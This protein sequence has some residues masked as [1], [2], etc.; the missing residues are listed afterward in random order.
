MTIKVWNQKTDK[1]FE[2]IATLSQNS[3][4]FSLAISGKSLFRVG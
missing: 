4:V 3:A 1:S 2:C